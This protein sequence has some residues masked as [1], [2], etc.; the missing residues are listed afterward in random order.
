MRRVL[1][2]SNALDPMLTQTGAYEVLY[3]AASSGK[4]EVLY[5]HITIDEIAMTPDL[6]KRQW[7][8]NLLV[9]LGQPIPTSGAVFDVSRFDFCRV[10]ADDDDTFEPL[11]SGNVKHSR[12]ALI[13]HT[14]LHEGCALVTN[15]HR[16]TGRARE[17]GAEVL[18]TAELLAEFG[19]VL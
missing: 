6:E 9:F 12:D 7:L 1:L 14:A 5:T 10:M 18:T 2:D 3:E 13:G 8:L 17:Q 19:F 4:L 16:L 11:R 15:E